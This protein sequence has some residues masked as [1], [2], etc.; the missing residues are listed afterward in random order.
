MSVTLSVCRHCGRHGSR[1]CLDKKTSGNRCESY[2]SWSDLW[3]REA[4]A[5]ERAQRV[6]YIAAALLIALAA[7]AMML[8]QMLPV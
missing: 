3:A 7:G 4:A 5:I 1:D 8:P 6:T 2:L